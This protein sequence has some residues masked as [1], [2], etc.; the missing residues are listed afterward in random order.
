MSKAEQEELARD[1][2]LFAYALNMPELIGDA[3][4][5]RAVT[6]F[7]D[8]PVSGNSGAAGGGW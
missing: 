6:E 2:E 1:L 8:C 7:Q 3:D 4:R 5:L